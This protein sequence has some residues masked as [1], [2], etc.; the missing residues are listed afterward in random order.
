MIGHPRKEF[1]QVSSSLTKYYLQVIRY[2]YMFSLTRAH[3]RVLLPSS[4]LQPF[5]LQTV[6]LS[7]S[8][9]K[10]SDTDVLPMIIL[11]CA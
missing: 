1:V 7:G 4:K 2:L 6:S 5:R 3:A 9:I 8:S 11:L 10:V